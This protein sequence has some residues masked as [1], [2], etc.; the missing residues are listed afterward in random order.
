MDITTYLK[1]NKP[2]LKIPKPDPVLRRQTTPVLALFRK[3]RFFFPLPLHSNLSSEF[4][5]LSSV[6]S[7]LSSEFCVL[8]S[9]FFVCESPYAL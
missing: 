1:K 7:V 4:S 6:F 8:S 9:A 3:I 2:G 5:V